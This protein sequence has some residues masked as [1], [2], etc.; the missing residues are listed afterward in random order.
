MAL[1]H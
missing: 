1:M